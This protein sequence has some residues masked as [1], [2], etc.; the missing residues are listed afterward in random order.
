MHKDPE[1]RLTPKES[2]AHVWFGEEVP[3]KFNTK[4]YNDTLNS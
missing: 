1:Q 3:K 4:K 2:L